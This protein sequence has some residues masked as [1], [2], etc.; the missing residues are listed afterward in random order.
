MRKNY[1]YPIV[2]VMDR[3]SLVDE[4]N[5]KTMVIELKGEAYETLVGELKK[6]AKEYK[7]NKLSAKIYGAG[8]FITFF[9]AP[10]LWFLAEGIATAFSLAGMAKNDMKKYMIAT[11]PTFDERVAA[12][13]GLSMPT[14]PDGLNR[15]ILIRKDFDSELDSIQG[16]EEYR[17]TNKNKC[18]YCSKTIKSMKKLIKAE[19]TIYT[20]PECA[21]KT[22]ICF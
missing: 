11:I 15:F 4:L 14:S 6:S 18:P 10:L 3:N 1:K 12:V 9:S 16:L 13:F 20:C 17:F 8:A 5:N 2:S 21:K 19:D 22:I 7:D